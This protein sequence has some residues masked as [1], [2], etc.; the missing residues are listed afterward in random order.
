MTNSKDSLAA[1]LLRPD[2]KRTYVFF[3]RKTSGRLETSLA[4]LG[5]TPV[6]APDDTRQA[7]LSAIRGWPSSTLKVTDKL[8]GWPSVK[9]DELM[10]EP[11]WNA[12]TSFAR[13]IANGFRTVTGS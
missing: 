2:G 5:A 10:S 12:V 7:L 13:D 9:L 6:Y 8:T 4:N 3:M 1:G 11:L